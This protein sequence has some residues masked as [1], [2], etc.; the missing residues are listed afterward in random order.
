[1]STCAVVRSFIESKTTEVQTSNVGFTLE[2]S[3]YLVVHTGPGLCRWSGSPLP[4]PE[5]DA[6]EDVHGK[7]NA[8]KNIAAVSSTPITL[9]GDGLED[10]ASFIYLDSIVDKQGRGGGGGSGGTD[11]DA[12]VRIGRAPFLQM[13]NTWASPDLTIN[14]RIRI[15]NTT[16]KSV[17]LYEAET[18]RTTA[19]TLKKIQTLINTYVRRIFRIRWPET[20][21][22]RELWKR[23]K[24]QPEEDYIPQRRWSWIGHTLR[25]PMT[26]IARQALAWNP[27]EKRKRGRPRNTWRRDLEAETKRSC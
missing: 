18:R 2:V 19:A 27:Q 8:L 9:E 16:V 5:R 3:D 22:N 17:L 15:F 11:V 1:M 13:K 21:S 20:I 25:K 12:K 24:Q 6:R 23:I 14:I 26:C 10:V 4:Y 7:S